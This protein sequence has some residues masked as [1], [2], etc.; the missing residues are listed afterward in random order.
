MNNELLKHRNTIN[1]IDKNIVFL[2]E[3]R[4]KAA[5]SISK[6][7]KKNGLSLFQPDREREIIEILIKD[8]RISSNKFIKELYELIFN[9]SKRIQKNEE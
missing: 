6:Y 1:K 3:E 7:K 4:F 9:E 5:E 2:L 8:S